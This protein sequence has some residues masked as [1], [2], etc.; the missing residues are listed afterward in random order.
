MSKSPEAQALL[1]ALDGELAASAERYGRDLVWSA[2]E[3]DIL[4]MI[5]AAV[6]RRV[7]LSAAYERSRT[8]LATK[9]KIAT[10]L[11]LTEQAIARLYRQVSTAAPAP[12]SVVS[13]KAQRAANARWTRE[14]MRGNANL[15]AGQGI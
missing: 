4:G 11:R 1:A 12:M 6:D 8:P 10:E 3:R 9:L 5:G 14:R 7:E 2:A 15:S 13:Q